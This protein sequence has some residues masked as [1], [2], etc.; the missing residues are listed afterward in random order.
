MQSVDRSAEPMPVIKH[1]QQKAPLPIHDRLSSDDSDIESSHDSVVPVTDNMHA[2]E[3]S[4]TLPERTEES[5][6][7]SE[8]F[9]SNDPVSL[10]LSFCC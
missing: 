4:A 8:Y 1:S 5:Q 10:S 2:S 6:I 7:P 3:N 9:D